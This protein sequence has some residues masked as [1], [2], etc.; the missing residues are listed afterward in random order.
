MPANGPKRSNLALFDVA[1]PNR[2]L[3]AARDDLDWGIAWCCVREGM[4]PTNVARLTPK[5]M[6]EEGW[7]QWIR[8]KNAAPRRTLVPEA[9]RARLRIFLAL[10]KPTRKTMWLRMDQLI[11][12]AGFP[13]GGPRVLRKTFILNE[14]RRFQG[15]TDVFLLVAQR[16]GC[17]VGVVVQHYLDLE[18][19]E[20]VG[21]R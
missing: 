14:L 13:G 9:D 5:N 18:Q 11:R 15:R 6:D 3:A 7:L 1:A 21:K 10:D 17:T 12:R 16:A 19:W 8:V 4:H 20:A 2:I